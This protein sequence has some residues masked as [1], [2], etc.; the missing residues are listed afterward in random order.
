MC[1]KT[2]SKEKTF[3]TLS[4]IHYNRKLIFIIIKRLHNLV[5]R[6]HEQV[7]DADT[8]FDLTSTLLTTINISQNNDGATLIDFISSDI[9]RNYSEKAYGSRSLEGND[10]QT[11]ISWINI[12]PLATSIF[13]DTIGF[14]TMLGPMD[15]ESKK[16]KAIVQRKQTK[17]T[18]ITQPKAVKESPEDEKLET[19]KNMT[20]IF[21]I[22]RK[23]KQ[24]R[25][26]NLVLSRV[27][28]S[29][30]V[31]N[32]FALSFLVNDGRIEINVDENGRHFVVPENDLRATEMASGE[33]SYS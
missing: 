26:E 27:S 18:E 5:Q 23:I 7:V 1:L 22:L 10:D 25:L 21:K 4:L 11:Q 20:S 19:D 8:L 32:I 14:F 9:L 3:K 17:P 16:R 28:F 13:Q 30:I 31:G 24:A 33:A 12:G 15:N 6:P 2:K 29:H